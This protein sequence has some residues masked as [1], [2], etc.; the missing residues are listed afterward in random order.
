MADDT[1]LIFL[2]SVPGPELGVVGGSGV[3]APRPAK[4]RFADDDW[5]GGG[6]GRDSRDLGCLLDPLL[7]RSLELN[8]RLQGTVRWEEGGAA[9]GHSTRQ[10]GRSIDFV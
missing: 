6:G 3:V 5:V 2:T 8:S 7:G 10:T 4:P 9:T 1:F